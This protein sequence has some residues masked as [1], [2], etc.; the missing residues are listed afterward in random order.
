MHVSILVGADKTISLIPDVVY[1]LKYALLTVYSR[2]S[3]AVAD[4]ELLTTPLTIC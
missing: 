2:F 4:V 3:G 1:R